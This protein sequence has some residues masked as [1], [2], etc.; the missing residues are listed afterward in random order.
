MAEDELDIDDLSQRLDS[1]GMIGFTESFVS[2]LRK[3]FSVLNE[4]QYPWLID[5]KSVDWKGVLCFGMGGS[6]AGGDFLARIADAS[7][8]I[9]FV[10]HRDYQLPTWWTKDWLILATSHSGNTEE[11]FAATETA[12]KHGATV[13]VIA[14][15][16]ALAGL[17]ELYENCH[18]IPSIAGQP[19]RTAF[20][21]LFSRQLA[22]IEYLEFVPG[23]Q[24]HLREEMLN[25]LEKA[26][27]ANDFR[28]PQGTPL[29]DLAISLRERPI[30]LLGPTELEPVLVRFKNQLNENAGRFA[31]IGVVPEMNHNELVAWGGVSDD[32]DPERSNQAT[33]FVT[34]E[35]M[36]KRVL[37][38]IDWMIEHTPTDYA[39]RIQ[40]EGSTLLEALLHH[41]VVMDWL[42][43]ALAFLHG[44]DPA[45]I[46]PIQ[47]LKA[48]LADE[49]SV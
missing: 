32:A 13:V 35:G 16:G 39:W 12:L 23:Q 20:G 49:A 17:C 22:L 5:I 24:P 10:V 21:H 42:T 30:S 48:F 28:T 37:R 34:W 6:A 14:T 3:G 47:A 36:H 41:C 25:R 2:D 19:P 9:P 27:H 31:R 43:I 45:A 8:S 26:I 33:L 29:L 40:G 15:G 4:N 46:R 7:G 38:R 18:L 1:E 44:K 11:T